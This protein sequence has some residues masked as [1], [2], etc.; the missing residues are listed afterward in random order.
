MIFIFSAAVINWHKL[1]PSVERDPESVKFKEFELSCQVNATFSFTKILFL[2]DCSAAA[3]QT[4]KYNGARARF[5]R[6]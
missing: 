6:N 1:Y 3:E 5:L 2:S 4:N